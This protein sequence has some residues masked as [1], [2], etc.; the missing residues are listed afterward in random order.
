MKKNGG[1]ALLETLV[2]S[3]VVAGVLIYIFVQFNTLSNN[4]NNNFKTNGVDEMYRLS[5]ID[6]Y[7]NSLSVDSKNSIITKVES[8]SKILIDYN[9]EEDTYNNIAYLDNQIKLLNGLDIVNLVITN[10]DISDMSTD[11]LSGNIVNLLKKI[12]NSGSNY[13]LIAEFKN[14]SLATITFNV[15]GV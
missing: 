14:G 11:D 10:S 15:E 13:R 4:Y 2:V 6:A 8:D 5:S 3:T 12:D 1:F 9:S 7:I